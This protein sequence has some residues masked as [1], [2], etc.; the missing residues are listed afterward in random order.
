M[1]FESV[2]GNSQNLKCKSHVK[3]G[4][5]ART[6]TFF[7]LFCFFFITLYSFPGSTINA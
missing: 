1:N 4:A 6:K 2:F 3:R 5:V 7:P